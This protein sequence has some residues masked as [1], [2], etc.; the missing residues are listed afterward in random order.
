V[1]ETD[2]QCK[3]NRKSNTTMQNKS[4]LRF[5]AIFV[6]TAFLSSALFFTGLSQASEKI[7]EI[8]IAGC[9]K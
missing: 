3:V 6:I 9:R 2:Q 8:K 5:L 4:G 1:V 7:V